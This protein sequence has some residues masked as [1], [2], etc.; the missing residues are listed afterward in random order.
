MRLLGMLLFTGLPVAHRSMAWERPNPSTATRIA[1]AT[2]NS[3]HIEGSGDGAYSYGTE[4]WNS[5]RSPD[6]TPTTRVRR[7]LVGRREADGDW[8]IALVAFLPLEAGN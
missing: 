4:I 7:V 2:I 5:G 6:A 3:D 8:R 1:S